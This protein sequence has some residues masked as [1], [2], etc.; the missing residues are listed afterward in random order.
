M[1]LSETG[2]CP[3][4]PF[5]ERGFAEEDESLRRLL[6]KCGSKMGE[7]IPKIFRINLW[8]NKATR[9]ATARPEVYL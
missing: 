5:E 6:F 8:Y 4:N 1:E 7:R 9:G 2:R 3:L